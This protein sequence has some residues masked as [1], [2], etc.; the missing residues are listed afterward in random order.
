MGGRLSVADRP[1]S[2]SQLTGIRLLG[3]VVVF[4]G[5][6]CRPILTEHFGDLELGISRLGSSML[7]SRRL[8]EDWLQG[9]VQGLRRR[10]HA[11]EPDS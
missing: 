6:V 3:A 1:P 4:T 5:C 11:P 8:P 10:G 9:P 2:G 7:G